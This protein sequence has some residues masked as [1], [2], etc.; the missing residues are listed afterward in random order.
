MSLTYVVDAA[1]I[2]APLL[3]AAF[4]V[5]IYF[6]LRTARASVE[7]IRQEFLAGGRPVVAVLDEYDSTRAAVQVAVRNVGRGPAKNISFEFSRPLESC[8]G[9]V[10]SELP[11]FRFG[12]TSLA[13]GAGLVCY[14]DQLDHLLDH[15]RR[16]GLLGA[17]FHVQVRYADLIG[18]DYSHG[19]DIQPAVYEGLRSADDGGFGE[20]NPPDRTDGHPT[21][22]SSTPAR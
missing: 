5:V 1:Q 22:A 13:P 4:I 9:F 2:A 15:L 7:E 21:K 8:D 12:L 14:W 17:D 18:T 3:Y 20:A 16:Q 6:Q 19:W 11:V 10:L